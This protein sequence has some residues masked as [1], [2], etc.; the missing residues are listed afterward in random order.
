[1]SN[2]ANSSESLIS[3]HEA[4]CEAVRV[5]FGF[6]DPDEVK[7]LFAKALVRRA[8]PNL[9][10]ALEVVRARRQPDEFALALAIEMQVLK[11]ARAAGHDLESLFNDPDHHQPPSPEIASLMERLRQ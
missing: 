4:L 7:S 5:M 2:E 9:E 3:E 8:I 6:R 11:D 1:M 10:A